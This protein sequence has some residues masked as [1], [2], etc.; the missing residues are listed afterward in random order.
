MDEDL[1]DAWPLQQERRNPRGNNHSVAFR[2][3]RPQTQRLKRNHARPA[4][5][6]IDDALASLLVCDGKRSSPVLFER[7]GR[8]KEKKKESEETREK[9]IVHEFRIGASG[10]ENRHHLRVSV[11]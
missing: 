1:L 2:A 5:Q 7:K 6:Q 3:N 10:E 11:T 8:R 9:Y 4:L